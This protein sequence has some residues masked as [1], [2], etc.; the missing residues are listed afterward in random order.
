MLAQALVAAGYTGAMTEN[1]VHNLSAMHALKPGQQLELTIEKLVPGGEG[2]ARHTGLT[3][4][5]PGG[6]PGDLLRAEVISTKPSYVR[7]LIKEVL[8][9]GPDRLDPP[10]PY[11][12]SCG[13]C[14]WQHQHYAAQLVAKR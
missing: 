9:P 11:V 13:G 5:V 14:Q 4:F 1:G 8:Q 2:L 10:C 12:A 7:A 6:L 3:V